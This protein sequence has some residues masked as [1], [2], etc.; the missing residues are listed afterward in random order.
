[1]P[2][3]VA[4]EVTNESTTSE[5]L[6]KSSASEA[7]T[8][9]LKLPETTSVAAGGAGVGDSVGPPVM[10]AE[11]LTD[12]MYRHTPPSSSIAYDLTEKLDSPAL[13]S[14]C[15]VRLVVSMKSLVWT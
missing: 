14:V 5:L 8:E 2:T 7:A 15:Q 3:L 1:M 6:M 10:S 4:I 11:A 13:S 9:A 12:K